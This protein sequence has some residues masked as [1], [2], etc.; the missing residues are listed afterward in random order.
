M[1]TF[2][3]TMQVPMVRDNNQCQIEGFIT[4]QWKERPEE[5]GPMD[6]LHTQVPTNI[7]SLFVIDKVILVIYVLL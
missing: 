3:N 1:F 7:I 2:D 4:K 6:E 5:V